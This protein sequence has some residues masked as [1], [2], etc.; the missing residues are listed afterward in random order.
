MVE[1]SLIFTKS[2]TFKQLASNRIYLTF[3]SRNHGQ[4]KQAPKANFSAKT[5]TVRIK[6]SISGVR[7]EK[8]SKGFFSPKKYINLSNLS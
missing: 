3:N 6:K 1:N 5:E 8:G 2:I 7:E 4:S